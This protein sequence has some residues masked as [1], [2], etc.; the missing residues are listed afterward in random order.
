MAS[1]AQAYRETP[2]SARGNL[3]P[4]QLRQ[5]VRYSGLPEG[6]KLF[7]LS[8]LN[9]S[10]GAGK[11]IYAS[12]KSLGIEM[13]K[14]ERTVQHHRRRILHELKVGAVIRQRDTWDP[15]PKC[16]AVRLQN[17]CESC[18][19]IGDAR[20]EFRRIATLEIDAGK[21]AAF[22]PRSRERQREPWTSYK[23]YQ[24][25]PQYPGKKRSE[26]G[27]CSTSHASPASDEQK[28]PTPAPQP[29]RE[30][31][32]ISRGKHRE[33]QLRQRLGI[34]MAQLMRGVNEIRPP[35]GGMG[36]RLGPGDEGFVA[37]MAR[38]EAECAVA[39]EFGISPD[40]AA[41]HLKLMRWKFAEEQKKE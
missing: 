35:E 6:A 36:H 9:I 4:F 12:N 31:S 2:T 17:Q 18:G 16:G 37:P 19:R 7:L 27:H 3:S 21:I 28:R 33:M 8:G 22:R 40:E 5:L 1:H 25:S 32:G 29:I 20:K 14:A 39:R 38:E 23:Q 13:R 30:A 26:S 41:D 15:C 10:G 24:A 34:R 11:L